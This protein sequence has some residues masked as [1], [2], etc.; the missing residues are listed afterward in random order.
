MNLFRLRQP[1]FFFLVALL[2]IG[3]CKNAPNPASS[4][5]VL[6]QPEKTADGWETSTLASVGMKDQHMV[7]LIQK[8]S[9][10]LYGEVHSVIV[11]KDNKLVFEQYWPGHDFAPFASNY[12][13]EY[14]NFDRDTPHDT[15]SATKSFTSALV[16]IALDRKHIQ[17]LSDVVFE[18]LPDQYESL[19]NGG[20]EKITIEHCLMMASGLEWNEWEL[21]VTASENDLMV[22]IRSSD[23]VGYLLSKPL[24]TEPGTHF[25]YNGGTVNLLG[26]MLVFITD[27]SVQSFSSQYLFGPLGIS[28]Y[29]WQVFQPSGI[30][31]CSGDIYIT[32]RDMAKFGQLFLDGGKWKGI[33]VISK[34]WV[35]RSTQY[36]IDPNVSWAEGYGYLWWLKNL[37]V[38][39]K[40]VNS[41]KAMGWG[42]QE[43]FVL[44]DLSMVVVFTGANYTGNVPTDEIVQRYVL[45]AA[46]M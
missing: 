41:I 2:L 18:Y 7:D 12:H 46:G 15:H 37:K 28:N 35:E 21:P 10:G 5:G 33:Q 39:N 25:Y 27:K 6:A 32:P 19:R 16:G 45:P 30:T 26:V 29:R 24:M 20:R 22:F 36:Q 44:R 14:L 43:I 17:S 9:S 38:N 40:T 23:P 1:F 42:G 3:R 11:V 31:F 13:G 8:I 34:E 4:T